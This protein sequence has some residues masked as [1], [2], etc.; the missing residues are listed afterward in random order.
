M[1]LTGTHW[2]SCSGAQAEMRRVLALGV[3]AERIVYANP[4]KQLSMLRY[5]R[6]QGVHM[7]TFDNADE[8]RKI[9]DVYPEAKCAPACTFLLTTHYALPP[10]RPPNSS[11]PSLFLLSIRVRVQACN[12]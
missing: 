4:C 8:L 2:R 6:A 12:D 9:R 10:P 1:V 5:A 7:L 3:S 11:I